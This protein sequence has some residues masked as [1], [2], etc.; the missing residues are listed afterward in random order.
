VPRGNYKLKF[1]ASGFE[2]KE[3]TQITVA[4]GAEETQNVQLAVQTVQAEV[5]VAS[6]KTI[7]KPLPLL[8]LSLYLNQT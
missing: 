8:E 6:R 5:V 1:E 2:S 7:Y 3:S 4:E